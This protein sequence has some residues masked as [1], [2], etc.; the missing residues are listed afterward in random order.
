MYESSLSR[1]APQQP[2]YRAADGNDAGGGGAD[3][4]AHADPNAPAPITLTDDSLVDFGDGKPVKWKDARTSRFADA[5]T[6]ADGNA[7]IEQGKRFLVDEAKKLEQAWQRY[8]TGKGAKP[9]DARPNVDMLE[10]IAAMPVVDG[11]TIQRLYR[12]GFGPMAQLLTQQQTTLTQLQERLTR[13]ERI[14]QT[15][16]TDHNERAFAGHITKHLSAIG[17]IKGLNGSLKEYVDDPVIREIARD[18]WASYDQNTWTDASFQAEIAKRVEGMVSLVRKM[19][20]K[21]A[22]ARKEAG[23]QRFINPQRN[24]GNPNGAAQYVHKGGREIAAEFFASQRDNT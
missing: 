4:N 15:T 14:G 12:E 19:D 7:R 3:P 5:S 6:V 24:N 2:L 9:K 1:W 11:R 20:K 8:E 17:E 18:V 13:A 21:F 22:E 23:R 10:E 16:E